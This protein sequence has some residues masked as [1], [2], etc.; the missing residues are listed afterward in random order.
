MKG[1]KILSREQSQMS[2][3]PKCGNIGPHTVKLGCVACFMAEAEER[4]Q[5]EM[6]RKDT[7]RHQRR[8]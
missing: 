8:D 6:E 5:H 4:A 2:R 3:C 1:I 7:R